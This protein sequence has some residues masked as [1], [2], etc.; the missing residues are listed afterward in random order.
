MSEFGSIQEILDFAINEEEKAW[1]FYNQWG[2][3]LKNRQMQTAFA[4]FAAEEMAHKAKL[5]AIRKN[6]ALLPAPDMVTDLKLARYIVDEASIKILDDERE[7]D[8]QNAYLLAIAKEKS[9]FRL[10]QDLARTVANDA[11]KNVLNMLAQEEAMHK[12][13][14]EIEYEDHF[15]QEN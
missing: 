6:P 10:Y 2:Q 14:L 4:E 1:H 15:L 11:F 12:L 7:P 8:V 3:R 9:A 13:K 5:E